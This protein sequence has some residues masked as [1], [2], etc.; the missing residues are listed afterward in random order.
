MDEALKTRIKR[1][2]VF[3]DKYLTGKVIDIG[4]GED[5]VTTNAERFDI[6]DGDANFIT[7]YRSTESYDTVHSSHCLEHMFNPD[8]AIKEWWA[9]I[10][11]GGHLVIVVPDEDLYEQGIWPSIFNNDH[12]STFRLHDNKS[13]SPVSYNIKDLI[14]ALPDSTIISIDLHNDFYNYSLLSKYP[15]KSHKN[16]FFF[17]LKKLVRKIPLYGKYLNI[18]IEDLLFKCF[19][20]PIDQTMRESLAQ[21][22]VIAIKSIK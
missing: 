10:K 9:L 6:E 11:P 2:K 16:Q 19:K 4:A 22:Q 18:K 8:Q 3:Y 20:F 13:W 17:L 7:R 21:I 15:P 12:K 14:S 1:G 5:L